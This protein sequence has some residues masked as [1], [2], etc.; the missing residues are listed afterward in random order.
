MRL[1][2]RTVVLL[3]SLIAVSPLA[4]IAPAIGQDEDTWPVRRHLLGKDGGDSKD[5]SG[6]ACTAAEAFPRSCLVVDDNLQ[7][8]QFIKLKT[9]ELV[10]GKP[11]ALIDNTFR[12]EAVELDGEGVAFF[13]GRYYVIGSHGHP[14]DKKGKL[15]PV[16]DA[17]EIRARITASSQIV[18]FRTDGDEQA[19]DVER[20]S[21]LREILAAE[22]A[23][24]PYLDQRLE[25]NGLTIEGVAI[26][27]GL[28]FAG[29]RGPVLEND[30][31]V[32]VSTRV[33]TLFGGTGTEH[34]LHRLSLG[35]GRGVRD[36]AIFEDRILILAGPA[37]E[38]PGTYA[39]FSWDGE[40]EQADPL[41]EFSFDPSRKPE[42]LLPLDRNASKLRVLIFFDGEKEGTPTQ[43]KV[44][45]R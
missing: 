39:L 41:I 31:A 16:R 1:Q 42:A 10:A 33:D 12:G 32:I 38:K 40:S 2:Y 44:P 18:R 20:T 9:S 14:R 4:G 28:L 36:M 23:L 25:K 37:A 30:N 19:E 35:E 17:E 5:V 27:D 8:A 29:M 15:D 34:R 21:R 26:K 22:P 43:V 7:A 11:V 45:W 24:Q 13:D 6:V 3:L